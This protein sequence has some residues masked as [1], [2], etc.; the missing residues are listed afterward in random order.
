MDKIVL[1]A[2]TILVGDELEE[3]KNG[4]IIVNDGKIKSISSRDVLKNEEFKE[5]NIIDLKNKTILPGLIE[6]HNHVTLDA[7]MPEHLEMLGYASE[8]EL[9]LIALKGLEDDL[10]AGI[11]TA[12]CLSDKYN[13]DI[14]MKKKINKKEVMG[15]NL[16]V[17]GTG[18]R[19]IHGSGYIGTGVVGAEEFRRSVRM[20]LAKGVDILKLFITPGLLPVDGEFI[21]SY[22]SPEEIK[23]VVE[24]GN[25]LNIPTVAHCVGGQGLK[26]CLE[27][28]V[29]MLEHLYAATD[30]D[31][32]LLVKHNAT[33]GLTSGIYMD[34]S[35][36]EF[37]SVGNRDKTRIRREEVI[38]NLEKIIESGVRFTLGTDAYHTFLY[39]EVLFAVQLG[40]DIKTALKGITSTAAKVYGI[41]HRT[42]SL[43]EGL[44]ADIIA[45]EGNPLEKPE[46]LKNVAFVMKNGAIY[47]NI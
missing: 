45:V 9:T 27:N 44:D 41:S 12:R 19:G 40:S 22:L 18:L 36:E 15:P 7:R 35:R 4:C 46:I 5:Y 21:P 6:G 10:M 32:E 24:E 30:K 38:K 14:V 25:R 34:S 3:L 2:D 23:V 29:G 17:A 13:I 33:I 47:K 1:L 37:L 26:D 20:N 43:I 31:V 39:R 11:T 8:S 42:G 16:L 28:G